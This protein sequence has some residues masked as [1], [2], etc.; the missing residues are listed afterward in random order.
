[1]VQDIAP[2]MMADGNPAE[3]RFVNKVGLERAGFA[4]DSLSNLTKAYK[5]LFR[6]GLTTANALARL[7][8]EL[9]ASEELAHLMAF[10]RDSKRGLAK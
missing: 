10:A 7:E 6:S 9:P 2:Y 3:T 8:T 4:A 1:V 5:V